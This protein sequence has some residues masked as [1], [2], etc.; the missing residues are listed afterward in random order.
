MNSIGNGSAF[1]IFTGDVIEG[2]V[3]LV[4][5]GEATSDL[6]QWNEQMVAGLQVLPMFPAI[7]APRCLVPLHF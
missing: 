7:G 5:Q 2:A 4:D 1:S 6:E 3:W